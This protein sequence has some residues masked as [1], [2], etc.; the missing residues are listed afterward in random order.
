M[1]SLRPSTDLKT[2]VTMCTPAVIYAV[3][4][5]MG[6]ASMIGNASITLIFV[7][8]LF[9]LL[10]TWFLSYL[11]IN[12]YGIIS[13]FFVLSPFIIL[14]LF[15]L[16]SLEVFMYVKKNGNNISGL[17]TTTPS[18]KTTTPS[19]KTTTPSKKTTTP[20]GKKTKPSEKN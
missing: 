13:W 16:I 4:A 20:S 2:S 11:C 17:Y 18:G 1:S 8:I 6:V 9:S 19:K 12:G 10:W 15:G 5:L 7:N 14:I 3:F